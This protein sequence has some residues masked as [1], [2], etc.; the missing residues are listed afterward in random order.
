ML[1][2]FLLPTVVIS[3]TLFASFLLLLAIKGS[4]PVKVQVEGQEVF[5]GELKDIVS[6]GVGATF[7]LG[8]GLAGALVVGLQQSV[9]QSLELEKQVT[10]LQKA[11]S[12][13]ESLLETLKLSPSNPMLAQL[14]W[15]LEEDES[16]LQTMTSTTTT[17]DKT[18][19]LSTVS[20]STRTEEATA[21]QE[22]TQPMVITHTVYDTQPITI[23]R[24]SV[25]TATSALPSAQSVLGLSQK[26]RNPK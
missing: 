11:I 12:E 23:D 17:T 6:P 3:S 4:K 24:L 15:F 19:D 21:V 14:S 1:K 5:Y 2:K 26:Y 10:N 20:T 13:K 7:S 18:Q 22:I 25:Q 16:K 9:R 8:L